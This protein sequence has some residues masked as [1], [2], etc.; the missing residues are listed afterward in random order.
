MVLL[1]R[2]NDIRDVSDELQ[3]EID[4][5]VVDRNGLF[6][7][8]HRRLGL[9][10]EETRDLYI[11]PKTL[12]DNGA[13]NN[14]RNDSHFATGNDEIAIV[15]GHIIIL[16][17]SA[18]D[19][20]ANRSVALSGAAVGAEGDD[21]IV[22]QLSEVRVLNVAVHNLIGFHTRAAGINVFDRDLPRATESLRESGFSGVSRADDND[23]FHVKEIRLQVSGGCL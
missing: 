3:V 8:R 16:N 18:E 1:L 15:A 17:E 21:E 13:E 11:A 6:L 10:R 4:D 2:L 14:T 19:N 12:A 9:L 22:L 5:G 23:S 20:W 7:F